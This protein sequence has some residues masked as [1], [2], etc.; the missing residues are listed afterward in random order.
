MCNIVE[1]FSHRPNQRLNSLE[2]LVERVHKLHELARCSLLRNPFSQFAG[3]DYPVN[4]STEIME[5]PQ[6]AAGKQDT[7][8]NTQYDHWSDN[9][10]ANSPKMSEE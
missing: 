9:G 10:C 7:A 4:C 1:R 8:A 3:L 6:G 2:H 5:W